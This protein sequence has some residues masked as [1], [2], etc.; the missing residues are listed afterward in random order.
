MTVITFYPKGLTPTTRGIVQR[1]T[2]LWQTFEK[3]EM[4]LKESV[5]VALVRYALGLN[6]RERRAVLGP[7]GIRYVHEWS[8]T[9]IHARSA[10]VGQRR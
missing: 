9:P 10:S 1:L 7:N 2:K 6:D 8:E 5:L 3:G 4:S